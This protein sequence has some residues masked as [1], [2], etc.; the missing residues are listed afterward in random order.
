VPRDEV[1]EHGLRLQVRKLSDRTFA[2]R[3][4]DWYL[5]I[6]RSK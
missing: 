1:S 4:D 5:T 6:I 2:S 3:L